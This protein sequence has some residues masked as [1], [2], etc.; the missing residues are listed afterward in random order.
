[1]KQ[2]ELYERY[3]D[4]LRKRREDNRYYTQARQNLRY[5]SQPFSESQETYE[6][7]LH[8]ENLPESVA[9]EYALKHAQKWSDVVGQQYAKAE[10][11]TEERR[12]RYNERIDELGFK[13]DIAKEQ[14]EEIE[15]KK[16]EQKLKGLLG[17]GGS[18]AGAAL[19]S[20]IPGVGTVIGAQV[21]GGLGSLAGSVSGEDVDVGM[22]AQGIGQVAGGVSTAI[23]ESK[24]RSLA[25]T[26][27]DLSP[28]FADLSSEDLSALQMGLKSLLDSGQYGK[29]EDFLRQFK[30][31]D[32]NAPQSE[33]YPYEYIE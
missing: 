26:I 2:S 11:A 19:G 20:I 15:R 22:I 27:A 17:A 24:Q 7:R 4:R 18:L 16:E 8:R 10:Q 5:L 13:R 12:A 30:K 6:D 9:Q 21:G 14:E 23:F 25:D 1:M 29:A 28:D 32:E 31:K 33:P 3:L